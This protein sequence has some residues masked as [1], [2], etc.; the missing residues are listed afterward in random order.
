MCLHRNV[1]KLTLFNYLYLDYY[2]LGFD[3]KLEVE[4]LILLLIYLNDF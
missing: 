4:S 3:N 1:N 2:P